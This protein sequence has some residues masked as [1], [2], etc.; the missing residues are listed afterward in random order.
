VSGAFDLAVAAARAAAHDV[1]D[2][3]ERLRRQIVA[4][5]ALAALPRRRGRHQNSSQR[6]TTFQRACLDAGVHRS[7]AARWIVLGRVDD[8]LLD[9]YLA[10]CR[11]AGLEATA[12]DLRRAARLA[13]QRPVVRRPITRDRATFMLDALAADFNLLPHQIT[14]TFLI[15]AL[16]ERLLARRVA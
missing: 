5:R 13:D 6:E 4:G 9:Q 14:K 3:G 1:L 16:Y 10:G 7:I 12:A 2:A 8:A 11:E 15:E